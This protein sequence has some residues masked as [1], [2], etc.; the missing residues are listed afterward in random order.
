VTV[1]DAGAGVADGA[2]AAFGASD[3]PKAA[4]APPGAAGSGGRTIVTTRARHAPDVPGVAVAG[5]HDGRMIALQP[6]EQPAVAHPW[7]T[8]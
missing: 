1:L 7:G 8:P 4:F 5:R 2:N 6:A 3:A